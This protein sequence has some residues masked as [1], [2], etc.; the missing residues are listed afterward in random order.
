MANFSWPAGRSSKIAQ[1]DHKVKSGGRVKEVKG[2]KKN[3]SAIRIVQIKQ[4]YRHHKSDITIA[5]KSATVKK[6]FLNQKNALHLSLP[7]IC[8]SN[9]SQ[10]KEKPEA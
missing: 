3:P 2:G 10:G 8:G 1:C 5:L 7:C 4:Y 9:A 6:I